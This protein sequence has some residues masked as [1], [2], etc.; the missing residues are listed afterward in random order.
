[1]SPF[2]A[3]P[4]AAL[5]TV[6]AS[7]GIARLR[8]RWDTIDSVWGAG[9]A[10]IALV[11]A[12]FGA[13][14]PAGW[15]VVALT[16][17]WG[18]RLSVHLHT[19]NAGKPEDRRYREMAQ[20]YGDR[21]GVLMF[22]RV[23]LVQG[24]VLW[25]VS[26]PVQA[27]V[28]AEPALPGAAVFAVLG[29]LVWLIGFVFE[30]V[31][32]RQ[33]RRFKADP[34]NENAVLDTGLWRYTRHP[35]YFGDACVWWGLYLLACQSFVGVATVLSPVLMTWL[36]ARGTGKPM[37]ER[38]LAERRPAYADYVARTSGFFPLPPRR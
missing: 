26:L 8:G 34:A 33:L 9:F 22:V 7:Y 18:V 13:G 29:G 15:A 5:A 20:R 1:M 2:A 28:A 14:S 36:L 23:Y 11:T 19:R 21:V 32:D 16:A 10:V 3:A 27:A 35:N 24:V 30:A 12:P 17:V 37:L 25:F 6:L 38:G 4:L 31:G